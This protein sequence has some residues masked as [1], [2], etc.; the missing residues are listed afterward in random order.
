MS[1]I[2]SIAEFKKYVA[3]DGNMNME[4][5]QPYINEAELLYIKDLLGADFF[6]EFAAA[7][8]ASLDAQGTPLSAANQ[9]LLPYVQ[10]SLA[11]YTMVQALPHLTTSFGE[12]GL[13]THRADQSDTAPRWMIEKL[14][15]TALH[16]G[17]IHADKLLEFLE[18]TATVS[19]YNTWYA[20]TSNTKNEGYLVNNTAEA[21]K[22]IDI[23]GSRR[24]F[25]KLRSKLRDIEKRMV[26]KLISQEQYE[27]LVT[28]IKTDSLTT[29][30]KNLM[31]LVNP[32]V[33]KRALYMQLPFMRVQINESGV[34]VY[35]GT[36]DLFKLGQLASD[37]DIKVLR[38][39]LI[40]GELGYLSDEHLLQQFLLDNIDTYPLVKA[41]GVYTKRPIPGPTFRP[42][43]NCENKHFIA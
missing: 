25:L 4:T 39:Q 8:S 19:V 20:S 34:F 24:V 5:L 30:N 35:S 10:R 16:N 27:E 2:T 42:E 37:A 21:S 13:R 38:Q 36:D 23:N 18:A 3:I 31:A 15:F 6:T 11:Y 1:L 12:M 9:N 26:P 43:N 41:S 29:A 28:Q 22:H 14:Q 32:I 7:Y 33:C 17:D 40:D